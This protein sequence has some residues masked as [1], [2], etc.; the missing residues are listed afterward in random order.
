MTD[1]TS[2]AIVVLGAHIRLLVV[3][4]IGTDIVCL[5]VCFLLAFYSHIC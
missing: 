3:N 5:S 2:F 1:S 4:S